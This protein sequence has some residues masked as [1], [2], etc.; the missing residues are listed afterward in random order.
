MGST[1]FLSQ[2]GTQTADINQEHAN[3]GQVGTA[4]TRFTQNNGLGTGHNTIHIVQRN[5]DAG[6]GNNTVNGEQSGSTNL[7]NV[8]QAGNAGKVII[9]QNGKNNGNQFGFT[10]TID[11]KVTSDTNTAELSTT[12]EDNDFSISQEDG[13]AE[14][15]PQYRQHHPGRR[16]SGD[17]AYPERAERSEQGIGQSERRAACPDD[18]AGRRRRPHRQQQ[19]VRHS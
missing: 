6:S 18:D 12:G 14:R 11:Q 2:I 9:N 7:P 5:A 4:L 3:F 1:T 19:P 16:Q 17:D 8:Y 13:P 10:H 15:Q